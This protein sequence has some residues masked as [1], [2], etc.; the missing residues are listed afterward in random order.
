MQRGSTGRGTAALAAAALLVW[1]CGSEAVRPAGGFEADGGA[2]A[3]EASAPDAG[4]ADAGGWDAPDAGAV[5]A[6][7]SE[8][9]DAGFDAGP[10]PD[11]GEGDAGL[12]PGLGPPYPIVLAHGFFGFEDFAGVDFVNYFWRVKD[13]LAAHGETEVFTPAVDPFDDSTVRGEQLLAA[14]EAVVAETGA[15]KVN[16]VGHSQGGLDARV[17][18]A[19]RPD[20]VASV[21]TIST[22][23]YGAP[24]ADV[25]LGIVRDDRVWDLLDAL[26]RLVGTPLWDAYGEETSLA[27]SLRQLS[28]EG[29]A[30]FNEAYPDAPGV[31][32]YSIAGRSGRVLALLDCAA[33]DE[34]PEFI[35]RDRW[36]LDPVDPLLAVSEAITAGSPLLPHP[37]DGLVRVED[38]KWGRFLGCVPADHLDE[39]GQLFGDRPGLLNRWRHE[40]FY[41][42]LVAWLRDQG[43]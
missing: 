13:D 35:R 37:N 6:G 26:L 20:L 19:L 2:D 18:A 25:A 9:A 11:G 40:V 14:V 32:Y 5:D 38:A 10:S 3:G 22:P 34:A 24:M 39:I 31:A 17:V 42:D 43:Y 21:T 27:T 15:A 33:D 1:G 12:E 29:A 16:L 36:E 28:R 4:P 30:A 8:V 41:R 7:V 23:H